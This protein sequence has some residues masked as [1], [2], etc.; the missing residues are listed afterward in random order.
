MFEDHCCN[1]RFFYQVIN[2]ICMRIRLSWISWRENSW[3]QNAGLDITRLS[4]GEENLLRF[5]K[6]TIHSNRCSWLLIEEDL[7]V[8]WI[9]T[10][11]EHDIW[12]TGQSF[13]CSRLQYSWMCKL[14]IQDHCDIV[15]G[16]DTER[17]IHIQKHTYIQTHRHTHTQ[18]QSQS[19]SH[20]H[21]HTYTHTHRH[22]HTHTHRHTDTLTHIHTHTLTHIHTDT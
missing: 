9:V 10:E 2:L 13:N 21:T 17:H 18:T 7:F 16:I 4:T 20:R 1:V 3:W 11:H 12:G 22:A 6:Q 8:R 14:T 19:Q 15:I 5:E